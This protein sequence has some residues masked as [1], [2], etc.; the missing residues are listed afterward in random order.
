ML[1]MTSSVPH[2]RPMSRRGQACDP[3]PNP[4]DRTLPRVAELLE[5]LDERIH[6]AG[7]GRAGDAAFATSGVPPLIHVRFVLG[8]T[9]GIVGPVRPEGIE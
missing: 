5:T 1:A 8:S 6:N 2:G 3:P 4:A 7:A 9:L